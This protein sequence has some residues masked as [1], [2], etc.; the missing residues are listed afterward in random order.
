MAANQ[1]AVAVT[2]AIVRQHF[3]VLL[4]SKSVTGYTILKVQQLAKIAT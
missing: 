4:I 3:Y 2:H 1:I